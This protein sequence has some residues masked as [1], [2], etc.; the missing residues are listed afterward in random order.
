MEADFPDEALRRRLLKLPGRYGTDSEETN[1]LAAQVS[2]RIATMVLESRMDHGVRPYPAFFRF[3]ADVWDHP[4]ATPDGRRIADPLSYG[5][6]PSSTCGGA[7]TAIL[8]STSAVA[9]QLSPCGAPLALS[10]AAH[11]FTGPEGV[12]RLGALV[13]G[14]FACGGFHIHFNLLS[15]NELRAAQ[16]DPAT[17]GEL[18]IRISG[19]STRFV[20]LQE[21]LQN[22]LIQRAEH[23]V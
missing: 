20:T 18:M 10:L 15:A 1:L 13:R 22:A 12:T 23:G 3:T 2:E 21:P 14:Y 19:L 7:P 5:C 4:Y 16:A 11:D 8:A 17:Y 6:G 9:H